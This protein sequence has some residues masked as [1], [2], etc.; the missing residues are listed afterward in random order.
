M[1]IKNIFFKFV[2]AAAMLAAVGCGSESSL[3]VTTLLPG[4]DAGTNKSTADLPY[5]TSTLNTVNTSVPVV[6]GYTSYRCT[7]YFSAEMDETSVE[8]AGNIYIRDV[9]GTITTVASTIT[10]VPSDKI[11]GGATKAYVDYTL[12]NTVTTGQTYVSRIELFVSRNVK[13]ILGNGLAGLQ[14][15]VAYKTVN[16]DYRKII[17]TGSSLSGILLNYS[18]LYVYS[19]IVEEGTT[20]ST[21]ATVTLSLNRYVS[22]AALV[23]GL[24]TL[25][26]GTINPSAATLYYDDTVSTSN[27]H[28][29]AYKI[30][31]EVT[32]L[33]PNSVYTVTF[34]P[35]SLTVYHPSLPYGGSYADV[36]NL[37]PDGTTLTFTETAINFMDVRTFIYQSDKRSSDFVTKFTTEPSDPSTIVSVTG[38]STMGSGYT[39]VTVSF[40]NYVDTSTLVEANFIAYTYDSSTGKY[41]VVPASVTPVYTASGVT[42][43]KVSTEDLSEYSI[44][45][46]KILNSVRSAG[47]L[48]IDGDGDGRLFGTVDIT[49]DGVVDDDNWYSW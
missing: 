15:N 29:Y 5:V 22:K 41:I 36:N 25:T 20:P 9:A 37:Y 33:S 4:S 48:A 19:F 35:A 13:D 18:P 2:L 1:R 49:G 6:S 17:F 45:R 32:G 46:L 7:V 23:T 11:A 39:T 44:Y 14:T 34:N 26:G 28:E 8:A 38:T 40:S 30:S 21:M 42:Q 24:F 10:Y 16:M 3:D 47:G 43:V 31:F 12:T 27:T